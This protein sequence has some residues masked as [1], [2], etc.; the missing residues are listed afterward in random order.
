[1]SLPLI[2][3][4]VTTHPT[5][6]FYPTFSLEGT[7][8]IIAACIPT[9]K[10][11]FN[12]MIRNSRSSS[13]AWGRKLTP[14]SGNSQHE[15]EDNHRRHDASISLRI[16]PP[17]PSSSDS[18]PGVSDRNYVK[19]CGGRRVQG[20]EERSLVGTLPETRTRG[21]DGIRKEMTFS[22]DSFH[23]GAGKAWFERA[24]TA[25]EQVLFDSV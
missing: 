19:I 7:I 1:M 22:L 5:N 11:L 2:I 20:P 3:K 10:P 9:I 13:K 16:L 24:R 25:D 4:L 14:D 15:V 18:P 23:A 8:G 12:P 17:L 6:A 21:E